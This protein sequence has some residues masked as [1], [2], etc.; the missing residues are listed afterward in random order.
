MTQVVVAPSG[1]GGP[2]SGEDQG[3][4]RCGG[5]P[6]VWHPAWHPGR[7]HP[8]WW[9]RPRWCG[10]EVRLAGRETQRGTQVQVAGPV[11]QCGTQVAWHQ[12]ELQTQAGGG[13]G[14]GG[15]RRGGGTQGGGDSR[16]AVVGPRCRRYQVVA[17][18]RAGGGTRW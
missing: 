3:E 9:W 8:G 4:T 2:G 12:A 18:P 7:W 16:Q 11:W 5:D 1:G 15:P 6:G 13:S 10:H 17:R 14:A